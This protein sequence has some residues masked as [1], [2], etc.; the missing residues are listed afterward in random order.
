MTAPNRGDIHSGDTAALLNEGP[1][2]AGVAAD[3]YR[4]EALAA[5]T[6]RFGAPVRP[7]GLNAAVLTGFMFALFI[8]V[9][10][11]L[12]MQRTWSLRTRTPAK[13]R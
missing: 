4:R 9:V 7:M 8:A 3:L 6:S 12:A 11:F 10:L 5:A 2:D 1:V 13:S